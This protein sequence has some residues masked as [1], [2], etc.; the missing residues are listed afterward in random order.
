[1]ILLC[2]FVLGHDIYLLQVL[3]EREKLRVGTRHSHFPKVVA[4]RKE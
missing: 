1:M 2:L 3:T 4:S